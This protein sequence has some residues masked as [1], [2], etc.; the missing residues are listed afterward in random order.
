MVLPKKSQKNLLKKVLAKKS[1][2][3]LIELLV[4]IAIV[5][6]MTAIV[7]SNFSTP[8][9]RARDAKRISDIAQLQLVLTYYFDRCNQYPLAS[10][11]LSA[12]NLTS[13]NDGC[14]SGISVGT[15]ISKWP[16]PPSGSYRYF[17]N[18]NATDYVLG[19]SLEN[20]GGP[21]DDDIDEGDVSWLT[22]QDENACKDG[23]LY[24]REY[25]VTSK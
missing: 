25:C 3:T 9:A 11:F 14:P 20:G 7:V 13:I 5:A 23:E 6:I 15:F 16:T 1:A 4:A 19:A 22:D 18:G 24:G 21:L 12:T 17:I 2:F 10:K 8:R